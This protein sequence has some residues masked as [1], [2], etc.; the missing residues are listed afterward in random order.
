M[1]DTKEDIIKYR[2]TSY[3]LVAIK[4]TKKDYIKREIK[5]SGHE[6]PLEDVGIESVVCITDSNPFWREE[7]ES[8]PLNSATVRG[9][10]ESQVSEKMIFALERLTDTETLVVYMKIFKQMTYK[11]I[12]G[13]FDIDWK[14]AGSIYTYAIKK[15]K[16]GW[17]KTNEFL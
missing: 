6:S 10:M 8:L 2:F 3:V 14:K 16:K 4:R 11:E 1:K 13:Y 9:Y 7:T 12:G 15:M 17:K 5:I